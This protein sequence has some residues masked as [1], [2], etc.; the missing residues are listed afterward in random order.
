MF[1]DR[2]II[3]HKHYFLDFYNSQNER[4]Q[5]KIDYVFRIIRTVQH[6]PAKFLKHMENTDGLYEVRV[7]AGSDTFRIFCCFD[8][9]D[10]VVL[11]NAFQKKTPKTPRNM[12][13]LG[14]KLRREYFC[15]SEKK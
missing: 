3:F 11:F 6:V 13:T 12:L 2:K 8:E 4:V 9:G 15:G 10:L 5:E 1:A 7:D 14:E